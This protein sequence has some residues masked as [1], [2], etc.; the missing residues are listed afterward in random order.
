M[1]DISKLFR[2]SFCNYFRFVVQ[3]SIGEQKGQGVRVVN[4]CF[5]DFETDNLATVT[6]KNDAIYCLVTAFGVYVY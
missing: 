3:V 1:T 6:Y 5:W 4:R 2:D